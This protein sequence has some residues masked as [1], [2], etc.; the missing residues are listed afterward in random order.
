[1]MTLALLLTGCGGGNDSDDL[2]LSMR[3]HYLSMT[4]IS[5][6]AEITA[7]YGERVYQYTAQLS[8]DSGSGRMEITAPDNIAGLAVVW[9][10]GM[11]GLEYDGASLTTG[12]LSPDGLSPADAMPLILEACR[13]GAMLD[14]CVEELEDRSLLRVGLANPQLPEDADSRVDVWVRQDDFSME[15]AEVSSGGQ[16]VV[17]MEFSQFE[18]QLAPEDASGTE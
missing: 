8:G 15:K 3:T 12:A 1:M 5:A 4:G 7:D 13:G 6:T 18:L 14:S 10:D 11:G 16:T 9:G 2:A 17:R